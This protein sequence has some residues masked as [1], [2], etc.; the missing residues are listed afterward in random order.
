MREKVQPAICISVPEGVDSF[1][2]NNAINNIAQKMAVD[3]MKGHMEEL[4]KDSSKIDQLQEK[5]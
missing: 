2:L 5:K 3:G 1:A 4:Q